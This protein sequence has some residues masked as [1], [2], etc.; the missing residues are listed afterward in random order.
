MVYDSGY[1]SIDEEYALS[2]LP[3]S[4]IGYK[5]GVLEVGSDEMSDEVTLNVYCG[6]EVVI[7][8]AVYSINSIANGWLEDG[9]HKGLTGLLKAMLQYGHYAE[10]DFSHNANKTAIPEGA[11]AI[12]PIGSDYAPGTDPDT[13]ADYI[14]TF[15]C[16]LALDSAVGMNIYI[17][18]KEGY[19]LE[20]FKIEVANAKI[21]PPAMSGDRIKA[22]VTGI[23]P[24]QML[25]QYS[26]TI[27][28]DGKSATYTR[29]VMNCAYEIE[30]KGRFV[31]LV[32][33]LYQYSKEANDYF[34]GNG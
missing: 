1:Q 31:Q 2:E 13:L 19:G 33:A 7:E 20:D 15:Q 11:P 5:L 32:E 34:G 25:D 23:Y 26:I 22:K 17:T 24:D 14:D 16:G 4:Q 21:D 3:E 30:Q 6:E 18:P 28:V 10:I 12:A 29:S 8:N 27:T 9:E